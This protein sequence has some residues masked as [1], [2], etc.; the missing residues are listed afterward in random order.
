MKHPQ[1]YFASTSDLVLD[2]INKIKQE[3]NLSSIVFIQGEKIEEKKEKR[4]KILLLLYCNVSR[5][6]F[7]T[8]T[9]TSLIPTK[10]L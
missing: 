6:H 4:M 5:P 7:Y 2:D 8:Y 1:G 3:G 9:E 10:P